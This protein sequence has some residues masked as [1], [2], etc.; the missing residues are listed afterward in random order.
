MA[1]Q[2]DDGDRIEFHEMAGGV[3]KRL[4]IAHGL[5]C[6]LVMIEHRGEGGLFGSIILDPDEARALAR[7]LELQSAASQRL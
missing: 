3:D 2:E 5:G 4:R 6:V 7:S 1:D